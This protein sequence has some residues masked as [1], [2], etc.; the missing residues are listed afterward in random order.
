MFVG[1]LRPFQIPAVERMVE[2][3]RMLVAYEMGLGKTVLTIAALEELFE[4]DLV[5]SGLVLCTASLKY[6]WAAEIEKFTDGARVLVID[7]TPTQRAAQY[8]KA[9]RAEY[10]I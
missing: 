4:S 10:V 9:G 6:Q 3:G 7:G 8:A 1:E 2:R 5:D